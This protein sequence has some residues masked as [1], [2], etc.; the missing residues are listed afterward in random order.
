[1]ADAKSSPIAA[2]AYLA[3]VAGAAIAVY[4]FVSIAKDGE[5]RRNCSAMCLVRPAYAGTDRKAPSFTLPDMNGK[6]ASLDAYR[7]KVVVLNFWTKTCGPCMQEMPELADLTRVL[8]DRGDV[9]VVTISADSGPD[10]VRDTLAAVLRG[11]ETPFPVLFD[12]DLKVIGDKFGTHLFPETWIIDQKG[13]IRARVDG[14]RAWSNAAVVELV[15][16]LRSGG[17]CPVDVKDSHTT[18]RGA[19]LC[20]EINGGS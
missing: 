1:M 14:A 10:D 13:I 6:P 4:S 9:A 20:E 5:L 12:P 7:G 8:R 19:R 3:F 17:Y 2:A 15:D 18:G 11:K 16:D